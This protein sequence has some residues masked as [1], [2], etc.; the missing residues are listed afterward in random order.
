MPLE[1]LESRRHWNWSSGCWAVPTLRQYPHC[2]QHLQCRLRPPEDG[3]T[4]GLGQ[5]GVRE[6]SPLCTLL[7]L[8]P[9]VLVNNFF[10]LWFSLASAP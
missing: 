2:P 9:C 1:L 10:S 5:E 8:S 6:G 4:C 3:S 7:G